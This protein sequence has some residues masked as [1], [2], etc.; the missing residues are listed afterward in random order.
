MSIGMSVIVKYLKNYEY[1]K[2]YYILLFLQLPCF[3]GVF[4]RI[5]YT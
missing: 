1:L 2:L 3:I 4:T 5:L